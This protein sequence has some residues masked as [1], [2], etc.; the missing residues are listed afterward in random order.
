[1]STLIAN[2]ANQIIEAH[3]RAGQA[4]HFT[5]PTSSMLPILAPGDRVIVRGVRAEEVRL[6]D[7]AMANVGEGWR[8]HRVIGRRVVDETTLLVTKGDNCAEADAALPAAQVCG[9]VVAVLRD[10]HQAS[11]LSRRARCAG[12]LLTLLSRAQWLMQR[13]LRGVTRR[14]ALKASRVL[15]RVSASLAR[16]I[17]GA[18]EAVV[19]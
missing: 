2:A 17:V 13:T 1:M 4:I 11:L 9:V 8:V 5:V 6:G 19:P 18:G 14:V 16:Q 10:G 3:L 12:M 15:L 7:I